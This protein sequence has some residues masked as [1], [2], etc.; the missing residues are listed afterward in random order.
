MTEPEDTGEDFNPDWAS[1]PGNT[2]KRI[3]TVRKMSEAELAALI[4]CSID[5]INAIIYEEHEI[6]PMM[7]KKLSKV[8]GC[9]EAFWLKRDKQFRDQKQFLDSNGLGHRYDELG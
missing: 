3:L 2:V 5:V 8:L 6:L 1:P 9:T 4:P 7:A